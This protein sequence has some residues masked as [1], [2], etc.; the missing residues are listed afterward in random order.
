MT[1]PLR[2]RIAR[3]LRVTFDRPMFSAKVGTGIVPWFAGPGL[4]TRIFLNAMRDPALTEKKFAIYMT[5]FGSEGEPAEESKFA[6]GKNRIDVIDLPESADC[7]TYGYCWFRTDATLSTN[8]GLQFHFQVMAEHSFAKTHG[9]AKGILHFRPVG[10][11]DRLI[12]W[13]DPYPYRAS[14]ALSSA[15]GIEQGFFLLNLSDRPCRLGH[16]HAPGKTAITIPA[17]GAHLLFDASI[18][19]PT[20]EFFGSAPFTFYVAMRRPNGQGLTLQHIQDAY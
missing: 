4:H 5:R 6:I 10:P 19:P 9:R 14:T 16:S 20:V 3:R 7:L 2:Q 8:I 11:A 17:H 13:L 12:A 15:P 18:G 1:G